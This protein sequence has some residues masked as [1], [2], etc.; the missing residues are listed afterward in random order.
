MLAE[1][2]QAATQAMDTPGTDTQAAPVTVMP[3]AELAGSL[4]AGTPLRAAVVAAS[5]VVVAA[6]SMGEAEAAASTVVAAATAVAD[7]G[8][9]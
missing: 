8:N 5:M 3:A 9:S 1:A 4:A 7:T 6:A 2:M